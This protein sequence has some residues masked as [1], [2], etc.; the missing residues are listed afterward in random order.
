MTARCLSQIVTYDAYN[1]A[2]AFLTQPLLMVA[3]S[4]AGSKW[5]SDDLIKRAGSKR[6]E[7]YI[8][9][10]A[11][12]MSMYDGERYIDEAILKLAPFFKESLFGATKLAGSAAA[13]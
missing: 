1:K 9:K 12:H 13:D 5:M 7:L 4:E 8:V 3:G 10:G 6:K 11:N 2:E